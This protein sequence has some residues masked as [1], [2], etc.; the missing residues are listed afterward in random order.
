M[1][2]GCD[3][4]S[5]SLDFQKITNKDLVRLKNKFKNIKIVKINPNIKNNKA[6]Q[7]IQV[8]W[9][10][11]IN[12]NIL[13]KMKK[14][15]WIH[16]GSTGINQEIINYSKSN[17]IK[18]SNTKKLFDNSVAATALG[19]IFC[20][21]RGIQYSL[22]SRG[23]E[24]HGRDFYNKIYY[25]LNDVFEKKILFV[26]YGNIA[27][28]ISKVCRSMGMEIFIVKRK[29]NENLNNTYSLK[30][31]N[32][33]VQNKDFVI[34]L[35]PS[36]KITREI[37]NLKVF[38]NMSKSSFFLNLGRGETVNEKDLE[39]I[40]KKNLISGA[41]LDVVQNEP[42]KKNFS[43]L[44][45]DNVIITPHIAGIN[46]RY[47]IDQVNLFMDNFGKFLIDKKLRFSI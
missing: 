42:F 25:N 17:N 34:N 40:I 7:D 11:R 35:L 2:I 18:V 15:K 8:Y 44:K 12:M 5:S 33:A 6:Y 45:Y 19:F 21:S 13:K 39:I 30:N 24:N 14:L 41:G 47:K 22:Y 32:K 46:T 27:K 29:K 37:F 28:K 3:L 36:T 31:L 16:Y 26:G 9:G 4:F 38:N 1:L 10:N 23:K 20:L 43:L